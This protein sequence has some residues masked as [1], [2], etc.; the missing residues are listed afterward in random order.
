MTNPYLTVQ[1]LQA[2][3]WSRGMI[4]ALLGASDHERWTNR[5]SYQTPKAIKLYLKTR[6]VQL[7]SAEA[8][9]RAQEDA[10]AHGALML[11]ASQTRKAW[12]VRIL[13]Q[14][15]ALPLPA[16]QVRA[17]QVRN[18]V[19][20]QEFWHLHLQEFYVWQRHH[21][22]LMFSLSQAKRKRAGHRMLER[23]QA[24]VFRAYAWLEKSNTP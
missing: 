3:R 18:T 6:V 19:Q 8:F 4:R 17:V 12:Q 22:H 1:E 21:E 5:L 13:A 7:E 11:R 24:A 15:E 9:T 10:Q 16:V 14:Y 2:R 23:Y 20:Q